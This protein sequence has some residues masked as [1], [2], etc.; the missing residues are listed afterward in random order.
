MRTKF[1]QRGER[2]KYI[3]CSW[4]GRCNIVKMAVLLKAIYRFTAIPTKI[5]NAIF[6]EIE[7]LIFMCSFKRP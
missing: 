5:P 7:K 2:L 6:E 4:I 1:N 3:S